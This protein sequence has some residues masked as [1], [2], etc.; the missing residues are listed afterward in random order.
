MTKEQEAKGF[1]I[2]A[3]EEALRYIRPEAALQI[4]GDTL[5]KA[6]KA[7][8]QALEQLEGRAAP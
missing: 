4:W 3:I 5:D 8:E 1:A 6:V 7:L 2:A